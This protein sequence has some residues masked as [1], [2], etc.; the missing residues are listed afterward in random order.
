MSD[1]PPKFGFFGYVGCTADKFRSRADDILRAKD[2]PTLIKA[3]GAFVYAGLF[4]RYITHSFGP[5]T[6]WAVAHEALQ[7][8]IHSPA[9]KLVSAEEVATIAAMLDDK[10]RGAAGG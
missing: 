8:A 3:I 1:Q 10:A 9:A 2:R 4:S 7:Y 5:Y 6:L